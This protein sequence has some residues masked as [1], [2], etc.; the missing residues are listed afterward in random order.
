MKNYHQR[1]SQDFLKGRLVSYPKQSTLILVHINVYFCFIYCFT[2]LGK[3]IAIME[4]Y[5][6][7]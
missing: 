4:A 6:D 5:R 2:A 3:A 7:T 1:R